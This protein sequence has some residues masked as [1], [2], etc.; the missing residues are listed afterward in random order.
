[1]DKFISDGFI[2]IKTG[3]APHLRTELAADGKLNDGIKTS[4]PGLKLASIQAFSSV[5]VPEG[6]KRILLQISCFF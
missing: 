1:M 2:L 5:L 6:V 4:S 3:L